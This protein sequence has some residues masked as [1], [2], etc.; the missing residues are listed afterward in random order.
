MVLVN[1]RLDRLV[2]GLEADRVLSS[3][4]LKRHY[5]LSL[6]E[7]ESGDFKYVEAFLAPSRGSIHYDKV[8]FVSLV[9]AIWVEL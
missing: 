6:D 5:G 8:T 7:L 4:Q 3:S 1:E 9:S 2:K